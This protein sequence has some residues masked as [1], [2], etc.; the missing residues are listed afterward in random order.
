MHTLHP[1]SKLDIRCL[2]CYLGEVELY[3][4]FNRGVDKRDVVLDDSDRA[5][6]V[7][8]LYAFNNAD[9]VFHVSQ[10]VRSRETAVD[11]RKLLVHIHAFC[12]MKNHYHLILSGAQENGVPHFMQKLNMGYTKYFNERYDRTG[13]L[14]QGK[15][16]KV[17][18]GNDA[19][20]MYLPYYIHLNPLDFVT[21]EWRDGKVHNV[22][23]A[24]ASLNEYRW[25]SHLD[26]LGKK[27]FPSV[28]EKKLMADVFGSP[29][30]YEK[31]L[32][33]I[34]GNEHRTPGNLIMEN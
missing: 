10:P 27:N 24:L 3:H 23:E 20:Y 29:A 31:E 28:I 9:I 26:Y 21:P 5:R 15:Y 16:K 18:V 11:K 34:I 12:L 32:I 19:H 17:L 13:T 22:K 8:D 14:W 30:R 25:S 6:F 4:V 1:V 7:H 33:D 2:I